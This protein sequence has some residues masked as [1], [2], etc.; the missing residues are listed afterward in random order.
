MVDFSSS[1]CFYWSGH[2][3][4]IKWQAFMNC[5]HT[6]ALARSKFDYCHASLRLSERNWP[7][8]VKL[9]RA[10]Q[11]SHNTGMKACAP[12]PVLALFLRASAQHPDTCRR[13]SSCFLTFSQRPALYHWICVIC[14]HVQ[15]YISCVVTCIRESQSLRSSLPTK[16]GRIQ[17]HL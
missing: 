17:A 15:I 10:Q 12:L 2:T 4:L 13:S 6:A 8:S 9:A 1:E 11:W 3:W 16:L 5:F 14:I 7:A